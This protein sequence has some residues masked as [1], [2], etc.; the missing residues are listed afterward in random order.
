MC[1]PLAL[2]RSV[3]FMRIRTC[4]HESYSY[5]N[6]SKLQLALAL[7]TKSHSPPAVYPRLKFN[8]TKYYA[9]TTHSLRI[10]FLNSFNYLN[11]FALLGVFMG[12]S[13]CA[14]WK[15]LQETIILHNGLL[16]TGNPNDLRQ[17]CSGISAASFESICRPTCARDDHTT[18]V[19]CPCLNV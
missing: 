10:L 19:I 17:C 3:P 14:R 7:T 18:C 1:G 9:T 5:E 8:K 6:A 12:I 11:Q 13:E 15:R 16:E 4:L 2:G